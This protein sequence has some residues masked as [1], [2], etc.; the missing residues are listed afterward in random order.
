M[1][2]KF[3][4]EVD[5][6]KSDDDDELD[7]EWEKFAEELIGEKKELIEKKIVEFRAAAAENHELREISPVNVNDQNE[8][9]CIRYL[10][11]GSWSIPESVSLLLSHYKLC[12]TY[13]KF[14]FGKPASQLQNLWPARTQCSLLRR[15]TNG[16]RIYIMSF[17]QWNTETISVDDILNAMAILFDVMMQEVKTQI[18]GITLIYDIKGFGT[19]HFRQ[20]GRDEM[21]FMGAFRSG[22]VPVNVRQIH[23]V[24]NHKLINVLYSLL[25]P[26]VSKEV[27]EKVLFHG[28]DLTELHKYVPRVLLPESL[29]GEAGELDNSDCVKAA[30]EREFEYK[31]FGASFSE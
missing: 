24:N 23:V 4:V 6:F 9:F 7:N 10:R 31:K 19:N 14:M 30:M 3:P 17:S 11:A 2:I 15:D 13:P 12:R 20:F 29:G 28:S 21:K 5:Q 25:K 8:Q 1:S 22:G 26:F 18:S 27:Q 16:R